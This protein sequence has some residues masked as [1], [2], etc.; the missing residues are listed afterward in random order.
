MANLILEDKGSCLLSLTLKSGYDKL[1][2]SPNNK[3]ITI[4]GA[5]SLERFVDILIN[6]LID[7]GIQK[8]QKVDDYNLSNVTCCPD[9]NWHINYLQNQIILI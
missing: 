3:E 7:H 8:A 1:T 4:E 5:V 6:R 2:L 9:E